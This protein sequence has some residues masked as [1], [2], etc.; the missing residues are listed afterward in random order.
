LSGPGVPILEQI[1][2]RKEMQCNPSHN[3]Y[4]LYHYQEGD[5]VAQVI[6]LRSDEQQKAHDELRAKETQ[7]AKDAGE[8]FNQS[9]IDSQKKAEEDRITRRDADAKKLSEIAL[10]S[11]TRTGKQPKQK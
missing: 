9:I 1:S 10:A 4:A 8:K 5:G 2:N 7:A 11:P 3:D 6:R